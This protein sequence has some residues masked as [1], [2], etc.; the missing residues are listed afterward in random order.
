MLK[1]AQSSKPA[2]KFGFWNSD[3]KK[4]NKSLVLHKLRRIMLNTIWNIFDIYYVY[5]IF[6]IIYI[7]VSTI[8]SNIQ[9]SIFQI[10]ALKYLKNNLQLLCSWKLQLC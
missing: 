2:V 1:Q 5:E 6:K 7:S 8:S 4:T 9:E 10:A 3:S